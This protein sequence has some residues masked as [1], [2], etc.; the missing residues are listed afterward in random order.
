LEN[1]AKGGG[2]KPWG[3]KKGGN[4]GGGNNSAVDAGAAS[5]KRGWNQVSE[6]LSKLETVSF[7][8]SM[9]GGMDIPTDKGIAGYLP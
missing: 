3:A 8:K 9:L 1:G 4:W 6:I 5:G 2:N 7:K